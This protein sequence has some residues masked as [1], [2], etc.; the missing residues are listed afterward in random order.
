MIVQLNKIIV[1]SIFIDYNN[2]LI[3][4]SF[5]YQTILFEFIFVFYLVF[6]KSYIFFYFYFKYV[7]LLEI[8]IIHSN[9]FD[10]LITTNLLIIDYFFILKI[11]YLFF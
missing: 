3:L 11:N 9:N 4:I 10:V 5:I 7:F 1:R 8:G 6:I 2:Y